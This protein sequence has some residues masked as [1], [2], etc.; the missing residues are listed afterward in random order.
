MQNELKTE[1]TKQGI[2]S[3]ADISVLTQSPH[4][5][6]YQ[7]GDYSQPSQI[8]MGVA[9]PGTKFNRVRPMTGKA[10]TT[11]NERLGMNQKNQSVLN[12]DNNQQAS[13]YLQGMIN[14]GSGDFTATNMRASN[15]GLNSVYA[16]S[17][18]A[19]L[20]KDNQNVSEQML[21]D[22]IPENVRNM[23]FA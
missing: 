22:Q 19:Y 18:Y 17:S 5:G 9:P 10:V 7:S 15:V 13:R 4:L 16:T 21:L 1:F 6:I 2:P 20:N 12:L 11:T 14:A 8:I 23:G 3:A